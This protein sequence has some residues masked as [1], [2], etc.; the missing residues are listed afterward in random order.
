MITWN[1]FEKIDIRAGTI[2]AAE[3]FPHARKPAYR[4]RI[5]FGPLGIKQSSAQLTNL[6][7]KEELLGLQVLAVVNFPPKQIANFFSECLVLGVYNQNNDVV[8][9]QPQQKVENGNKVG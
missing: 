6:Y 2:L 5:D 9:L 7:K 4:L 8:L 1:D 3:D